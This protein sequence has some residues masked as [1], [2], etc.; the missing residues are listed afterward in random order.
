MRTAIVSATMLAWIAGSE[1]IASDRP[2]MPWTLCS[3]LLLYSGSA[4]WLYQEPFCVM[5][6][7]A[8]DSRTISSIVSIPKP[9]SGVSTL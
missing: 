7:V 3:P 5:T 2:L 6:L 9:Y 4:G 8:T 1:A